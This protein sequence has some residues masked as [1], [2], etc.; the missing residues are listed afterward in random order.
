MGQHLDT[1]L[2]TL[3]M[4]GMTILWCIFLK[5]F[6]CCKSDTILGSLT[7]SLHIVIKVLL[8]RMQ[9]CVSVL[10]AKVCF[11]MCPESCENRT[12]CVWGK[13]IQRAGWYCFFTKRNICAPHIVIL[14]WARW[15]GITLI[16]RVLFATLW[17]HATLHCLE[18]HRIQITI[19]SW[20]HFDYWRKTNGKHTEITGKI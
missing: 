17:T 20:C 8:N 18:E 6:T 16:T 2:Q 10:V 11:S 1:Q 13:W 9:N 3:I 12:E 15:C 14:R 7:V 19:L 4:C 5:H